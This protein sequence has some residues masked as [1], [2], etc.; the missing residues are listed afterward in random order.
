MAS[1]ARPARKPAWL[2]GHI[3]G[4]AQYR[5]LSQRIRSQALH[6]VCEE[7]HCPNKGECWSRGVATLMILGDTC[8][9]SCAFCNVTTGRPSA[10][11]L[12]ESLRVAEAVQAMGLRYLTLTS[13]DRDDLEDLG[14]EVWSE[15]IRRVKLACPDVQIECLVPDFQG[16]TELLQLVLD[17]GP[18]VLNH[19]LETVPRLQK[20]IRK[21][22]NWDWSMQVLAHARAQGFVTKTGIMV[23]L[24]ETDEEVF[25]FI[26]ELA[27][28]KIEIVTIGQYLQ[29]S[30]RNLAVQRFCTPQQFR[31]Y[32]QR[33]QE[34]GIPRCESGPLVRSSWHAAETAAGVTPRR[35]A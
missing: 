10:V 28:Q 6:T 32:A 30:V 15:T 29:P 9:R 7:A 11:D 14:A 22:A 18:Q 17:A 24:G 19:N 5:E 16:R 2:K 12:Q 1:E 21:S 34:L 23:G 13:V 25:A 27:E 8:T 26:E 4:G 3:G 35:S 33:A 31:A 20:V